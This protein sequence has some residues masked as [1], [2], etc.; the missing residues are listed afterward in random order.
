MAALPTPPLESA[1]F[2]VGHLDAS[3]GSSDVHTD[4]PVPS[5][6]K[7]SFERCMGDSELSYYLPS[8]ESGVNDMYLHIGFKAPQSIAT[9]ARV[10]LVWTILRNRHPLL[11]SVVRMNDYD[12]VKFIFTPPASADRA[13]EEARD[14]FSFSSLSKD[15]LLEQYLN[16]PR[17]LSNDHLS[18]LFFSVPGQHGNGDSLPSPPLTPPLSRSASHT[19]LN[20]LVECNWFLCATHFLGDGMALHQFANDY[21]SLFGSSKS[22]VELQAILRDEWSANSPVL[23]PPMEERL[24]PVVGGRFR[25]AVERIDHQIS[26][27]K[28]I[29]G[30]SFPRTSG[31][32]RRTIV[33]TV[34][35]EREDT[36]KILKLCKS[37][38]VSISSAIFALCNV[39]WA[40]LN[41]G[42]PGLPMMMYSALNIRPYLVT[43]KLGSESYWFLAIGY[44]NVVLPSFLPITEVERTFWHRA[45]IAKDQS[46]RAA[47]NPMVVSRSRLTASERGERAKGWAKEDDAKANGTWKAP[48]PKAKPTNTKP[49]SVA[50][51]GLSLLG[52]LDGIYKHSNFPDISLHTLTTGSRQR[53]GGML[54]FGYTFAGKLW[55]SLGYDENGFEAEM[56]LLQEP[57]RFFNLVPL[58]VKE[59]GQRSA[60]GG[61]F[62]TMSLSTP[63]PDVRSPG[64]SKDTSFGRQLGDS[65]LA[66]YLPSRQN[67]VND[68]YL[69]VGF[70]CPKVIA[71][72]ARVSLAWAFLRL[73]HPMLASMV[74]MRDYDNVR[75]LLSPPRT[76]EHAL[77]DARQNMCFTSLEKD[78][79]SNL[80]LNGPRTL[81][82]RR[83]SYLF[84]SVSEGQRETGDSSINSGPHPIVECQFFLCSTHFISDG[85][86]LIKL[87]NDF[88]CIFGSATS[89]DEL[90]LDFQEE[91]ALRRRA[92]FAGSP[93]LP[94]PMEHRLPST[95]SGRLRRAA[96]IV[97]FQI[98]QDKLI[99]GHP[100]PRTPDRIQHSVV[101]EVAFA[102]EDTTRMLKLCRSHRVS[103]SGAVFALCNLAWTRL[104]RGN[105]D[106]PMMMYS[107]VNVRPRLPEKE[108][109]H[110]SYLFL[111]IGY[112]NVVLP[113][114][115]PSDPN[116]AF[117]HRARLAKSQSSKE[118]SSPM[119][120]SRSRLMAYERS[121]RAREW[122]IGDATK[123]NVQPPPSRSTPKSPS[124]ATIGV[125]CLGNVDE[126]FQYGA[127]P[128]LQLHSISA[129]NRQK[130]G[131]ML[132]LAYT[133]GGKFRLNLSYD[134]NGVERETCE[135]FWNHLCQ[136]IQELV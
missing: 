34:A 45:R 97:D 32:A 37:R 52:N 102:T 12:D 98:N 85:I 58:D 104:D 130:P 63:S 122:A 107:A 119:F 132:L 31:K 38:G 8:R 83:L 23:P 136:G 20:P 43:N 24:P 75:F 46:T 118:I 72:H 44:F 131:G 82:D 6:S 114:F 101:R 49:P 78:D 74:E 1:P 111:A 16:G 90:W 125:S 95:S 117:W 27:D 57:E 28:C 10:N 134:D 39:A 103:V 66:Y 105:I 11:A 15:E 56:W 9:S 108:S 123:V 77:N 55:L 115:L 53:P 89:D 110:D 19:E 67:G 81:S 61:F 127:F 91:C 50:T 100:F 84:F 30:H 87:A 41:K 96:E 17:T 5:R 76:V 35:F 21:F 112:F 129:G 94:H 4:A 3:L 47:K 68:L 18:Y 42:N 36:V 71:T 80:F 73:R 88:F 70:R 106:M 133:F 126:T 135:S 22:D 79:L 48:I 128:H 65:E 40:R 121:Q 14:N 64:I 60:L 62:G 7:T 13:I 54:L 29:G 69:D 2:S 33:P 99:G 86:S 93:V 120:I 116:R 51:I 124:I 26:Q 59:N 92:A 25:H 113:S 109:F